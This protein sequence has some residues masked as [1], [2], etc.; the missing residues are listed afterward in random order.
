MDDVA[1]FLRRHPPFDSLD[2]D[3]RG[4]GGA[5]PPCR[6]SYPAGAPILE[7]P[8][9]P[10]RTHAYVVRRGA[11]ELRSDGR[12]LD[13]VGEGE[14]F[15]FASILAESPL[16]FVARAREDTLVYRIAGGR[17]PAGA[18][19]AGRAALRRARR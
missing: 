1:A 7:R 17:D 11:V 2:A 3:G 9:A 14:L 16:G 10:P 12:L 13:L 4:G 19:A 5:A 18:R 8:E 15:G 6:R